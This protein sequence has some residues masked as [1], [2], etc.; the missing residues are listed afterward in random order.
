MMAKKGEEGEGRRGEIRNNNGGAGG[1]KEEEMIP[2]GIG[3]TTTP[4]K[5]RKVKE[6]G[7]EHIKE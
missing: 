2:I 1:E 5:R 3:R 7:N 6:R 4:G